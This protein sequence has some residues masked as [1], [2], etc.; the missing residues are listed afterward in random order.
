VNE[1]SMKLAGATYMEIHA[2]GGG[3]G[4]TVGH[5]R[6]SS[7]EELLSLLLARLRRFLKLGTTLLEAKSGYGL[8]LSTELKQLR[9]IQ[10][11]N[12]V[13]PVELVANYCG[14]HSVPQGKTAAEAVKDIINHQL[15][16][17]KRQKEEKSINPEFIDVFCEKNV[18]S[19]AQSEEI[20][21]AGQAAG[22]CI[23]FHG[24]ELSFT[25]S[26]ELGGKLKATAISHLEHISVQGM[27]EMAHNNVIAVL[28]PTTAYI[29]RIKPPPAVEMLEN[30]MILALGSDF[31]PNAH[32]FSMPFVMNLACV[33]M[34][35]SLQQA[36]N[37]ATINAAASINRG[38]SHGSLE[39]GKVGDFVVL[40][41]ES[42]DNLIY[43]LVDPPI[44]Y[45]A[46]KGRIV[47]TNQELLEENSI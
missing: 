16:Q 46:K 43:E 31:N 35:L 39:V 15:P 24:D 22:L 41:A 40:R 45:V 42:W 12:E 37:A 33:T 44:L 11:A 5:T 20:L 13:Q 14:A 30:N 34:K 3:I 36:L 32:C 7:E 8:E 27:K 19:A 25:G 23:N 4:K 26:A 47:Y 38:N 10:R 1:F 17:I 29:L 6:E 9:V 21:R 28:L 2:K 18:F